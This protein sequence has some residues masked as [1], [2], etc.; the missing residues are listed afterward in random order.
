LHF[1][2]QDTTRTLTDDDNK[3]LFDLSRRY[4]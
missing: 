3:I 4:Q 2:P 1:V